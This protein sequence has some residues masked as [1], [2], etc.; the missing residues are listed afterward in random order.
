MEPHGQPTAVDK[1]KSAVL[2]EPTHHDLA[3]SQSRGPAAA[4]AVF[5][6][7]GAHDP[8]LRP[9]GPHGVNDPSLGT[10]SH[11]HAN[12]AST[13]AGLAGAPASTSAAHSGAHSGVKP[14]PTDKIIGGVEVRAARSSLRSRK[15]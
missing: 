1:I 4:A 12:T 15:V 10:T 5:D 7:S 11:H 6:P 8:A 3:H 9:T 13:G 14:T 2:P